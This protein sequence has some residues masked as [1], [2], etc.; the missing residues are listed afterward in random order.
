MCVLR[1]FTF[2]ESSLNTIIS[3]QSFL[4]FGFGWNPDSW[5]T[6]EIP[7]IEIPMGILIGREGTSQVAS[8]WEARDFPEGS[9]VSTLETKVFS[10]LVTDEIYNG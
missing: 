2:P 7:A 3:D 5:E 4:L 10:I 8:A 1:L 9:L 6:P